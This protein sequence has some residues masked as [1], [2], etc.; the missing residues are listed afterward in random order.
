M[1]AV[2]EGNNLFFSF[3]FFILAQWAKSRTITEDATNLRQ[4]SWECSGEAVYSRQTA[5]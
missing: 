5:R 3:I 2:E 4:L 1:L